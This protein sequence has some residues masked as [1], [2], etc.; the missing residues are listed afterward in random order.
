MNSES[1][2]DMDFA[3]RK[4]EKGHRVMSADDLMSY[5][6]LWTEKIFGSK[7][8]VED[9]IDRKRCREFKK[10]YQGDSG[11]ILKWWFSRKNGLNPRGK[12][13]KFSML[14]TYWRDFHDLLLEEA[15]AEMNREKERL[16]GGSTA[17]E[18]F[19]SVSDFLGKFKEVS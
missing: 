14:S 7:V 3:E 4:L 15:R 9:F 1:L 17:D 13:F 11:L 12:S 16:M 2:L 5:S 19:V 8:A 10:K 6:L 18:N